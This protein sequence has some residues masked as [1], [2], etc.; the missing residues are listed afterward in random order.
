MSPSRIVRREAPRG[1]GQ[2]SRGWL[3]GRLVRP[4]RIPVDSSG[5]SGQHA[6]YG[7]TSHNGPH[8]DPPAQ[9]YPPLFLPNDIVW[10]PMGQVTFRPMPGIVLAAGRS[11]RMG[12]PKA[13]LPWPA[14]QVPLVLHV[15]DTLRAAGIG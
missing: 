7:G 2:H 1:C 4:V 10:T 14:T 12:R 3:A 13:L 8:G 11:L 15:A 6:G 9:S 5:V